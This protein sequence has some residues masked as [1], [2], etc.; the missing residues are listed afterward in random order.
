MINF[1]REDLKR[2]CYSSTFEKGKEY[3][4]Q[5]RISNFFIEDIEDDYSNPCE[6][7]SANVTGSN[8]NIYNCMAVLFK[9]HRNKLR[10]SSCFCNCDAFAKYEGLCKHSVALLLK[11]IDLYNE[12]KKTKKV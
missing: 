12:N 9:E 1:S 3:Y 8:G 11:Y 5:N 10:L 4:K 7:I 2:L 6:R